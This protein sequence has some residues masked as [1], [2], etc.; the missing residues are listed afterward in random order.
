MEENEIIT[1]KSLPYPILTSSNI[2]LYGRRKSD[3]TADNLD[4]AQAGVLDPGG[5]KIQFESGISF[6]AGPAEFKKNEKESAGTS[7]EKEIDAAVAALL[8][9]GL[10]FDQIERRIVVCALKK[11]GGRQLG[12]ARILGVG[13]GEMQ[14]KIKKFNIACKN[15]GQKDAAGLE[16]ED[17]E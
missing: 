7:C 3:R 12:A 17:D 1:F 15:R 14:Y 13:R 2:H 6:P 8:D 5:A 11:A 16:A 4:S 10:K 9:N